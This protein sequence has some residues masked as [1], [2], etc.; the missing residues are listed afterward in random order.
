MR[1][2]LVEL[3]VGLRFLVGAFVVNL[4]QPASVAASFDLTLPNALPV[5]T[6]VL[7]VDSSGN[8]G[9]GSLSSGTVTSFSAGNLSPLFSSS[10]VNATTTP[11]LSFSLSNAAQNAVFAG[12]TSGSGIPTYRTLVA[13]DIPALT[14]A[15]ISDFDTQVRTSRLDQMAV[16]TAAVS[17][18]SQR[19]T[20]VADPTSAQDAATKAYVDALIQGL[21]VK[22]SVRAAT[23]AN[24]TL[25]GT[26]TIDG[27]ALVAGDRVLVKDQTTGANNG[28]YVVAA[29][30]WSRA[31][32]ADINADV[33][34][35]LFVF[36]TEGSTN[37]DS[38]WTLTT[39]DPITIG[40]T[41]LTFTQFSGA[42]QVSAGAGLTKTG[43]TLDI[44]GTAN[45]VV[46]NADSI[47]IASTYAGQAT[48]TT[49]GTIATG[50]WQ[51][52]AIGV[53]FGGTGA[54]TAATAR[55]NLSAA[56]VFR[57]SFTNASLTAG[58]LNLTHNLAQ[59]CDVR[60]YDNNNK[61]IQPDDVTATSATA[62]A[63]DL[64]SFGTLS[65][66]WNAVVVG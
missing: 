66:T 59:F 56:G 18:N 57:Q 26:Q 24:I 46:V 16:P 54:N 17:A 5:S 48:I 62:A 55:S 31:N 35:G 13:A 34:A 42:G 41:S 53:T 40:T 37:A 11:A 23:T 39:N 52:T 36:V 1:Y 30:A 25:S 65:G 29:G 38:G 15:K 63:V 6:Q 2:G 49:L 8:M 51:G 28:I 10:V 7:T 3:L 21:D 33:T 45:R 60:I 47:D 14:A 58:V 22:N 50:T 61:M 27:V 9:Y 44:V 19:I 43:N 32:D 12:P 20:S 64:S 4:K